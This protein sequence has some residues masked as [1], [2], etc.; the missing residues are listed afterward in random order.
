MMCHVPDQCKTQGMC[1]NAVEKDPCTVEFTPDNIK[2]QEICEKAV[3]K[4]P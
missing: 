4:A 3:E 2:T 1:I